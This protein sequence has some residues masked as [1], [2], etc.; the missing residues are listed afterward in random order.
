MDRGVVKSI[1]VMNQWREG[2]SR[3]GEIVGVQKQNYKFDAN[4]RNSGERK[5]KQE[6]IRN[7]VKDG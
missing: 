1:G 2:G 5:K 6:E 3:K 7:I 4:A